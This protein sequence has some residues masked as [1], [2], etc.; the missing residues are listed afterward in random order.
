MASA[1]SLLVAQQISRRINNF[2]K[3]IQTIATNRDLTVVLGEE[4]NDELKPIAVSL[5]KL[6]KA[7]QETFQDT[8]KSFKSARDLSTLK[9]KPNDYQYLKTN[10]DEPSLANDNDDSLN[11]LSQKLNKLS[12][13]FKFFENEAE[14]TRDWQ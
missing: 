4:N 11:E 5:N 1:L 14:K 9:Q 13:Q 8:Y 3:A 10:L 12:D 7:L 2:A 6:F